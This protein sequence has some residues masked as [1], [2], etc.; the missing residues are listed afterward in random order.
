MILIHK[1]ISIGVHVVTVELDDGLS[2]EEDVIGYRA[3]NELWQVFIGQFVLG[4]VGN[5]LGVDGGGGS[6]GELGVLLVHECEIRVLADDKELLV[7][8]HQ[9]TV[10]QPLAQLLEEDQLDGVLDAGN[11]R[12]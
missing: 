6:C 3:I 11:G 2:D 5:V 8:V 7:L 9:A 10:D 12:G 1:Q 4:E